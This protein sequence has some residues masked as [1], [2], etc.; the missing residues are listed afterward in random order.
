MK[1]WQTCVC[2]LFPLVVSCAESSQEP[3]T[4][5]DSSELADPVGSDPAVDGDSDSGTDDGAGVGDVPTHDAS[6]PEASAGD[7]ASAD[8][9]TSDLVLPAEDVPTGPDT[10]VIVPD[11]AAESAP[12]GKPWDPLPEG[13]TGQ[14]PDGTTALASFAGVVDS[15]GAAVMADVATGHWS[16]FW[17]YPAAS[18]SG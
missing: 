18:T 7:D 6:A 8:D 2:L 14:A 4:R 15:T 16:V 1:A 17:F 3:G 11:A 9:A 5:A 12:A 10:T 13:L